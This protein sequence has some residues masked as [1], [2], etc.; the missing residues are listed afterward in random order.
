M[1][2]L[3]LLLVFLHHFL[4]TNVVVSID[5][6]KPNLVTNL[7][8]SLKNPNLVLDLVTGK[9]EDSF[10][11]PYL[12]NA[13]CIADYAGTKPTIRDGIHQYF[14]NFSIFFLSFF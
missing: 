7:V 9:R 8:T 5:L 13:H 10:I 4:L 6:K 2:L 12:P 14:Y 11:G 3:L 1:F